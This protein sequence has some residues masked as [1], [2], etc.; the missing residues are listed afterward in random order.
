MHRGRIGSFL[1]PGIQMSQL[2]QA[3]RKNTQMPAKRKPELQVK[4]NRA[5]WEQDM[6]SSCCCQAQAVPTS[7]WLGSSHC[8]LSPKSCQ[9][10]SCALIP[11][12]PYGLQAIQGEAWRCCLLELLAHTALLFTGN[13]SRVEALSHSLKTRGSNIK[14]QTIIFKYWKL[15]FSD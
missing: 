4:F 11:A 13:S 6:G 9:Q 5:V 10:L 15:T 3:I 1:L 2:T 8:L 14:S 7:S 12:S